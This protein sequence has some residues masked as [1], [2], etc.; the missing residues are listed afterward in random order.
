MNRQKKNL[1]AIALIFLFQSATWAN[2]RTVTDF[3]D[4]WKF[5]K[6]ILL[7][8]AADVDD[9]LWETVRIPHT[10]NANDAQDGGNNYART[11]GWYRKKIIWNN[12]FAGK[13]IYIE[14]LAASLKADCYVNGIPVYTHKGGYN[15]FRFDITDYLIQGRETTIAIKVDNTKIDDIAPLS[16][17]FSFIGGLYRKIYLVT[18]N[19]IHVDLDDCGANGLYLTTTEVSDASAKLEIRAKIVNQS[20]K[21]RTVNLKAVLK[22]PDTFDEIPQISNP[23]FDVATMKPNGVVRVVQE[24]NV[25]I[26]AGGSYEFKKQIEISNPRLW[27]GITDPY[28]YQVNFSISDE[29]VTLDAVSDYV[30]FRYFHADNTGFYL[31]GRLYPLRGVNRHQDWK[32]KGY[33]ITENEHN[34]DFGMIY[35]IGANAVRMAHYPQDPY[36][37]ELFDKY[38]IVVWVEIPFV[39]KPGNNREIFWETTKLQLKEMI[40]QRYNRPSIMF[41]GLQNEVSTNAYNDIMPIK[42]AEWHAFVK[43]ED[44]TGRLTTQAQAGTERPGWTT[45]VFGQNRYPGWYQT[46]TYGAYLDGLRNKYTWNGM[47]LPIGLSEYG[48]GGNPSQHEVTTLSGSTVPGS[49]YGHN[50]PFHPE[51]YQSLIHEL[52]IKDIND[53]SW[54]WGTFVWNMFDFASDSRNEGDQPGINDKGLVTYDRSLKKDAFYIY[55]ANWNST[56]PTLHI[57]SRRFAERQAATTPVKIY[58]NCTDV[59]LL[60]NGISSGIKHSSATNGGVLEWADISLPNRATDEIGVNIIVAKGTFNGTQIGDTVVWKR[61]LST[62]TDLT[63]T[64]LLVDNINRRISL[65]ERV[66]ADKIHGMIMPFG[67]ATFV[68]TAADGITPITQGNI[69]S[70]MKLV[71]TAEDGKTNAI[72]EFVTLHIAYKK[73]ITAD[74]Y[75]NDTNT[76]DKAVDGDI[77]TRWAAPNNASASA[78]HWLE[79]DLG[80]DYVLNNINIQWFNSETNRRAYKYTVQ[81]KKEGET[82]YTTL[83]NRLLNT[84][85]DL[86][87]DTINNIVGRYMKIHITGSTNSGAYAYPSIYEIQVNGWMIGS[88]AYTIDLDKRTISV[89]Y[90]G[91]NIDITDFLKNITFLGN[92]T[93]SINCGAYY[94]MEGAQ[95]LINDSQDRTTIFT[96]HLDDV[97]DVINS[98]TSSHCFSVKNCNNLLTV[99][100]NQFHKAHLDIITLDGQILL[101]HNI[102]QEANVLLPKSMYIVKVASKGTEYAAKYLMK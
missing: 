42:I 63:S 4:G 91:E 54:V 59:E 36:F 69:L 12:S 19:P 28:R 23:R 14:A 90:S 2:N 94:L 58:T 77:T 9:S 31:N 29:N 98:A 15:A 89:P 100:L 62:N 6:S 32:N 17:D 71:V 47:Q 73:T 93:H 24:T 68:V 60:V 102:V 67:G 92:E 34:I 99:T 27:N 97:N 21:N 13:R 49:P 56:E 86:V 30:G 83:V 25:T 26:L 95:L 64:K 55:K 51:E 65:T 10:W 72:Y 35:E 82:N 11:T 70:G 88:T 7:Q 43:Q 20:S 50:R 74:A 48:A 39:D 85:A 22:N 46:G 66:L 16:G 87:G 3:G 84:K 1:Y 80:Q 78:P 8:S 5:C 18:V 52:A 44:P 38:G 75:E 33:A 79:V 45:D 101:S 37:H 40:R 41:W 57:A 53:R 76:P 96:I 81:A 61:A